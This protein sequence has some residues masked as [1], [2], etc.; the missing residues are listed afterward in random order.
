MTNEPKKEAPQEPRCT[1]GE[2]V[3]SST[4]SH[5]KESLRLIAELKDSVCAVDLTVRVLLEYINIPD[6]MDVKNDDEPM[7]QFALRIVD[8]MIDDVE[9]KELVELINSFN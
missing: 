7:G 5:L 9:V 1:S 6:Y 4:L 8:M 2:K 3:L